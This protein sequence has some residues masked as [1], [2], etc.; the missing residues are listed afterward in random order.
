M[1]DL[2]VPGAAPDWELHHRLRR[3]LEYGQVSPLD[4]AKQLDIAETTVRN[5]LTGRTR[6]RKAT[7]V[8]WALRRGVSLDWL[9]APSTKWYS[10]TAALRAAS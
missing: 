9:D 7:V 3:A 8:F 2:A 1:S 6:P 4:M 5:Y 10:P